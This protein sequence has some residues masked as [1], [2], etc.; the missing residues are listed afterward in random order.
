MIA[1]KPLRARVPLA[2][3]CATGFASA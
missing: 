3:L 2:V 1:I